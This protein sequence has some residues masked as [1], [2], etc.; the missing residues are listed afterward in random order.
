MSEKPETELTPVE[1]K[2]PYGEVEK[3]CVDG[4]GMKQGAFVRK[5]SFGRVEEGF[6]QDNFEEGRVQLKINDIT[7][8]SGFK[9]FG[10]WEGPVCFYNE[11]NRLVEKTNFVKGNPRGG[12]KKWDRNGNLVK[13]G[14]HDADLYFTGVRISYYDNNTPK[15]ISFYKRDQ[16]CGLDTFYDPKGVL[17]Q[18]ERYNDKG[19]PVP[20][21]DEDKAMLKVTKLFE[22][23]DAPAYTI[24]NEQQQAAVDAFRKQFP[25]SAFLEV[26]KHEKQQRTQTNPY[27]KAALEILTQPKAVCR[28]GQVKRKDSSMTIAHPV[29]TWLPSLAHVRG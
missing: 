17:V 27:L 29:F 24:T 5:D 6:Y 7:R 21:T 18:V 14:H 11:Q 9:H 22:Y 26:F 23:K 10:K 16:L 28:H 25:N 20:L 2:L 1:I 8:C 12:T 13:L 3:C 4:L 19:V 15:N